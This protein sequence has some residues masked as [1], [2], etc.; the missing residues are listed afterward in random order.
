MVAKPSQR[1]P[2]LSRYVQV[3]YLASSCSAFTVLAMLVA[4]FEVCRDMYSNRLHPTRCQISWCIGP[5]I[6]SRPS[7]TSSPVDRPRLV[8]QTYSC[9][10]SPA[11]TR[12]EWV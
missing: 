10:A 7:L 2:V 12:A 1:V 9:K 5:Y 4:D 3:P 6:G 11:A 8:L